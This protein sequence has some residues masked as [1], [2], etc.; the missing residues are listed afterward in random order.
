MEKWKL[1]Q[2][3]WKKEKDKNIQRV[4]LQNSEMTNDKTNKNTFDKTETESKKNDKRAQK[5]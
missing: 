2:R 4:K 5:N 3:L 1:W